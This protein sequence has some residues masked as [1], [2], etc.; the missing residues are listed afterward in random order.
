MI[1]MFYAVIM[2]FVC[3]SFF[4][5]SD[6]GLGVGSNTSKYLFTQPY[7]E[8]SSSKSQI[9]SIMTDRGV[10]LNE[11]DNTLYY[12]MSKGE[13]IAY[14]FKNDKLNTIVVIPEA[15]L[16]RDEILLAFKGY[17]LLSQYDN[18]VYLDD[19]SNT[20]AEIENSNGFYTISWSQ[21]GL[22]MANAVNL[23][24]SVKWADVNLDIGYDDVAALTPENIQ[25]NVTKFWNGLIGWGDP[26]GAKKSTV[27]SDY[28]NNSSISGTIY[29]VA[30]AKW[31][32]KWRIATQSEFQ[33]LISA[34]VWTWEE[35]NGSYGYKVTGPNGN[36]IFLPT[37]G[38]RRGY[39]WFDSDKGYYWTG[40]MRS[41]TSP[42]PYV[43]NFDKA[44]KGLNTTSVSGLAYPFKN[45]GCA[46]RPVQAE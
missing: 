1:K 24:L 3:L 13:T 27:E 4:S 21:Y 20:I 11:D 18:L 34:C 32:G 15:T 14:G 44:H 42:Y 30:K 46:I 38:Y 19:S 5:C 36:S 35:R 39:S 31:G 10:L 16:S 23:G 2:A 28:P 37:T 40:T 17:T 26:T 8:W 33:E 6:E 25:D 7:M 41:E 12:D 9:S 29:D 43:L 45:F 22:E